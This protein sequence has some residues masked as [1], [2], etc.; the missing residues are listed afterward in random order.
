M[1]TI[2]YGP[3]GFCDLK[4]SYK[5]EGKL[6]VENILGGVFY[7]KNTQNVIYSIYHQQYEKGFVLDADHKWVRLSGVGNLKGERSEETEELPCTPEKRKGR[8]LFVGCIQDHWGHFLIEGIARVWALLENNNYTD[9]DLCYIIAYGE[10][11]PYVREIF[12][13]LG[14]NL[15]RLRRIETPVQYDEI[16]V[17]E[18]SSMLDRFWTDAYKATIAN[19]KSAVKPVDGGKYYLSRTRYKDNILGETV[20][21]NIFRQNDFNIIY[22]E[23]LPASK[24]IAIFSGADEIVSVSGT[25]A[26]NMMFAK[27][28][29]KCVILERMLFCNHTQTVINDMIA[30]TAFVIKSNRNFFQA[31]INQGPFLMAVTPWL[32]Q[33]FDE[34]RIRYRPEDLK[35]WQKYVYTYAKLWGRYYKQNLSYLP[36]YY[37]KD[38]NATKKLIEKVNRAIDKAPDKWCTDK[39]VKNFTDACYDNMCRFDISTTGK[40]VIPPFSLR[41]AGAE[42]TEKPADW[43]PKFG[44]TGYGL[45]KIEKSF[46]FEIVSEKDC[47]LEF[48]LR[49]P[50]VYKNHADHREGR[51]EVWVDYTDF[52]LNGQKILKETTPVWHDK[53]FRYTLAVKN[54]EKLGGH[55]EWEKHL[56][57][58]QKL[59]K[60]TKEL[61]QTVAL[62]ENLQH[63]NERLLAQIKAL[64]EQ[65]EAVATS[66]YTA[67][68][69]TCKGTFWYKR[70]ETDAYIK[71]YVCGIRVRKRPANPCKFI[72]K[73]L[74]ELERHLKAYIAM[75][76]Q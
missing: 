74:K 21:E 45:S 27:N 72:D 42:K 9:C 13:Y 28:T 11:K 4:P 40:S 68:P 61:E 29:A 49:G 43:M 71:T 47:T 22:P 55:I 69:K 30:A 31:A 63:T 75:K 14:I 54:G 17:P 32:Q 8:A 46:D 62:R 3:K 57:T 34:R 19:I 70:V 58:E 16:I 66:P 26:H 52:T 20:I 41:L 6:V 37:G 15:T 39:E 36:A 1:T 73:R 10:E 23:Q 18:I 53:P 2:L 7:P 56:T 76:R 35:V 59:A 5:K 65:L 33:Y 67:L 44:H 25:T 60:Q 64:S 48:T 51:M 12:S 38:I 50:C 24:Q